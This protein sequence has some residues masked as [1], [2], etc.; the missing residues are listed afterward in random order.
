MLFTRWPGNSGKS[1]EVSVPEQ[2][3]DL[4]PALRSSDGGINDAELQA[5][6]HP[7][8][9]LAGEIA[10]V[11]DIKHVRDTAD[12]PSRVAFAPDCLA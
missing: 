8:E 6:L 4:A 3:F 10:A 5:G 1:S 12:R 9:M 7:I 2:A 11:I